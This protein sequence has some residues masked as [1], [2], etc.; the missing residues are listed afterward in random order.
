MIL[1]PSTVDVAQS[2]DY[3]VSLIRER[4]A[5][6]AITVEVT[7]APGIDTIEIDQLR[8]KQVLLNLLS[9]A[10]K[11]TPDGGQV[12]I[13]A[14]RSGEEMIISVRD[15][16]PG[17]PEQDRERIFESFQ[18]GGR[19][20]AREED[21]GLGLTLSRRIV[22]LFG[23]RL[24]LESELGAGS[25]FAF[26]IPL[27]DPAEQ[28]KPG[29]GGDLPVVLLVDDDRA[30]LDLIQAYLAGTA[31]RM[32]R[33]MDGPEAL[34]RAR[35]LRPAGIIL[36]L[37][38]PRL[39]G[40]QVL[41]ELRADPVTADVPI[42]IVSV[43]DDRPRGLAMG[44]AAYLIKPIGRDDLLTALARAGIVSAPPVRPPSEQPE[45]A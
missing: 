9:N 41:A 25:T 32:E 39:D 13:R 33:A 7:V 4:A 29:D 19:G 5:K 14:D 16:G 43:V 42:V 21:T 2:L 37:Q 44:A 34:R 17:I 3:A 38:L 31:V 27:H 23:G 15:T 1:E 11:F 18:Q 28:Q 40:W 22:E 45:P 8:F 26:S 30:S 10:V 6:H 20:L 36:D 12:E 35:E 24:W